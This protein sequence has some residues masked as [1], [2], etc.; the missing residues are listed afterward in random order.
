MRVETAPLWRV[1]DH[2]RPDVFH[3]KPMR[4]RA[5]SPRRRRSARCSGTATLPDELRDDG[6][7]LLLADG[8]RES[9]LVLRGRVTDLAAE[10][11]RHPTGPLVERRRGDELLFRAVRV[12]PLG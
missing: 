6:A 9:A 3:A 5:S 2:P 8:E 12:P 1:V 7:P 11:R 10:I 4:R